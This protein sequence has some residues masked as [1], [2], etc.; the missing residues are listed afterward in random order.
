MYDGR[1]GPTNTE[2]VA[3][4][5]YVRAILSAISRSPSRFTSS[6]PYQPQG[7]YCSVR[8]KQPE[9]ALVGPATNTKTSPKG[10]GIGL[11]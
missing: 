4:L 8:T 10:I 9:M 2:V 6:F 11:K 1:T 7:Y 3:R 5:L